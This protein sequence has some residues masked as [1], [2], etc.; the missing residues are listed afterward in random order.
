MA[1]AVSLH[2]RLKKDIPDSEWP[3]IE[4]A[5]REVGSADE[6]ARHPKVAPL[7]GCGV[8]NSHRVRV[9]RWRV[10]F[11]VFDNAKRVVFAVGFMEKGKEDYKRAVET[12]ERRIRDYGS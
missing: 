11:T 3:S 4:G 12:H 9:G 10:T 5:L 8:L 6:P 7:E 2:K 1:Y